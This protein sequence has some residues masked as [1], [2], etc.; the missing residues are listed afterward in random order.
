M[1]FVFL[2][3]GFEE[4]E[5]LT[6]VDLLRRVGVKVVTVGIT[7]KNVCGT[8]GISV[9]ADVSGDE[10]VEMVE[11]GMDIEM[12]V[13]PGGMPGAARLDESP[14][15]DFM[16]RMAVR[17]D[18]YMAAICAAPMIF[19]KRDLLRLK[20]AVC[21][22]GFEEYL[23]GASVLDKPVVQDGR[24]ITARAMG[25]AVP[26]SLQLVTVLKGESAANDLRDAILA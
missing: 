11:N 17:S 23:H 12:I 8:H 20:N 25:A 6:P 10:A 21:Y 24:I 15:V 5:A 16:I 26:F 1:V 19:G 3:D 14:V 2:A 18:A 9:E 13:L 22:P 7:G 4:I